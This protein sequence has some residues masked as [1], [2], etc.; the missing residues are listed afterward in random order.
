MAADEGHE[1]IGVSVN[2]TAEEG[3]Y[4]LV[5]KAISRVEE[6]VGD[7]KVLRDESD[8]DV[9]APGDQWFISCVHTG[10]S[11]GGQSI[12]GKFVFLRYKAL[13]GS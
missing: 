7:A 8:C 10:I 1:T 3:Y 6:F 13:S 11:Q 12:D 4:G 9:L 2:A 5:A